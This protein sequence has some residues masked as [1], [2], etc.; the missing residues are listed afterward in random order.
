MEPG[1]IFLQGGYPGHA[2]TVVYMAVNEKGHKIF[3][4]AQSYMPAQEQ[5]IVMNPLT[6]DVWYSLDDLNYIIT[7]E[8]TF[9]PKQLRRFIK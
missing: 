4:L 1:D 3:M 9:T 2:M 7:P 8:Y 6:K 5:Q